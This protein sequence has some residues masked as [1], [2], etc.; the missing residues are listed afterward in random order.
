M[1][2]RAILIFAQSHCDIVEQKLCI[3]AQWMLFRAFYSNRNVNNCIDKACTIHTLNIYQW[4]KVGNW[5]LAFEWIKSLFYP[6]CCSRL[7]RPSCKTH[8]IWQN[9]EWQF[10]HYRLFIDFSMETVTSSFIRNIGC[11]GCFWS[12]AEKLLNFDGYWN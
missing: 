9:Q 7:W 1:R 6:E 12:G 10:E 4:K 8:W 11:N 5:H 2:L 3:I